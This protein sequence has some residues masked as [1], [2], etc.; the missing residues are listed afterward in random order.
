MRQAD[1]IVRCALDLGLRG[2]EIARLSLDDIAWQAGT[3]VLRH[4]KGRREDM[5][6]LQPPEKT[7]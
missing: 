1:A 6:P 3:L 4:T 2:G 7:S 5:L